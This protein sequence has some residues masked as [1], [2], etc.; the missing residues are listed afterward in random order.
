MSPEPTPQ[1]SRGLRLAALGAAV[2][3]AVAPVAWVPSAWASGLQA[4][5]AAAKTTPPPKKTSHPPTHSPSHSPSQSPSQTAS[6]KPSAAASTCSANPNAVPASQISGVTPWPQETLDLKDAWVLSQGA[7]QR[8]AVIDSGV[9][10]RNP[11]LQGQVQDR[12]DLTG[13][14]A[15]DCYGHGTAVAGIVAAKPLSGVTF[16]GVAPKA[17]VISIKMQVGEDSSSGP[18]V[19]MSQ[20]IRRAV[21][22][23]AT[24]INIS[25]TTS[26][27]QDLRSAVQYAQGKN[28]LIVAAAGNVS[29]G[30]QATAEYPASYQGV[31]SVAA[32]NRD[33]S[34]TSFSNDKSKVDVSA[35]GQGIIT[36]AV[37]TGYLANLEG[38]SYASPYVAGVAALVRSR[39]PAL[40][41]LDVI[42]RI[43]NTADGNLG[44]GTGSG[45]VNPVQALTRPNV[46][47]PL[48]Q[49]ARNQALYFPGAPPVDHRTR[50][51]GLTVAAGCLGLAALVALAGVIVPAGQ[52]RGWRPG[53]VVLS[54]KPSDDS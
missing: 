47:A 51:L 38:T 45:M 44:P 52:R 29:P 27:S 37:G 14:T 15:D 22:A 35:P 30:Q 49:G 3:L 31:L 48:H 43:V 54:D 42:K 6:S 8:V 16:T 9:D 40:G 20:A 24:I 50:D 13:T 46:D 39:F 10:D 1:A 2:A 21:D 36:L 12:I 19:P 11:Q 32:I 34:S 33:G 5:P 4:A 23:G 18:S 41:Y 26:D 53:R 7:G 28:V 17:K 25:A